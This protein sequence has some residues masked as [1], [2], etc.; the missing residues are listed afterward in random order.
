[1]GVGQ[2]DGADVFVAQT[3][4]GLGERCEVSRTN[5]QRWTVV[6][7]IQAPLD[8]IDPIRRQ[9]RKSVQLIPSERIL[10]QSI[11]KSGEYA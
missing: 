3:V 10:L 2:F 6:S 5:I 1:M 7:P 11:F 4:A 8:A 9:S